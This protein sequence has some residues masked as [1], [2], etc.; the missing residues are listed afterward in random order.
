MIS[1]V[2]RKQCDIVRK[3]VKNPVFCTN[4]YGEIMELYEQGYI[5]IDTDVIKVRADNGYG[6]MVTRRRDSHSARVSSMPDGKDSSPQGIY[7][8]VS[9]YDLQAANHIT[10][11]PN[12][13]DF[14][15]KELSQV[16]AN[17]GSDFWVIN[18]SNVRPHVYYLDAIR[19]IWFGEKVND[20]SHSEQFVQMYYNGEKEI[21][22][23]YREYAA[24]MPVY[25]KE[26]DEHAGEQLYTENIRLLAHQFLIERTRNVREMYWLVGDVPYAE[27]LAR[28]SAICEKAL[29]RLE[30][31]LEKCGKIEN[32]LFE[33]TLKLQVQI[34]TYCCRGVA[35]YRRGYEAFCNDDYAKSFVLF[36]DSAVSFEQADNSMRQAEYGVWQ[37]FY[38]ND[39]FADAKHT[40]YM[41]R[42]VMGLVREFGDNARHDKWYRDYCYAKEDRDVF[43]L[44]V[45]DNHMTDEELYQVMKERIGSNFQM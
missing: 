11:L 20:T 25:G 29:P 28:F 12:S 22:A 1:E 33:A 37:D 9:F 16:I 8:H 4:L 15:E 35:L 10:M 34:H 27:Q 5:K 13:V 6:R 17:G 39:C 23:C 26:P 43:L 30:A 41:I 36:G 42:K 32:R 14:V 45:L 40:A 38:Y 3:Y 44:L 19:K 2:I 21:A 24:A 7:Y 31:L 18:C